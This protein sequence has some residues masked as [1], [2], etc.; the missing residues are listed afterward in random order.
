MLFC[1]EH[2][3]FSDPDVVV[4]TAGYC[5]KSW[6]SLS[7]LAPLPVFGEYIALTFPAAECNAGFRTTDGVRPSFGSAKLTF[8]LLLMSTLG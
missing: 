5:F 8:E 7:L 2:L 4:T 3:S 1:D 6:F